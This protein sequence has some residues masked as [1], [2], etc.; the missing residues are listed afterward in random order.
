MAGLKIQK[1]RARE[2]CDLCSRALASVP[3][4]DHISVALATSFP[5]AK[6]SGRNTSAAVTACHASSHADSLP[7]VQLA[8]LVTQRD[9]IC[10]ITKLFTKTP[11]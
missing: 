1:N 2:S 8:P 9:A 4:G 3:M 6:S 5:V 10:P 7:R 11:N